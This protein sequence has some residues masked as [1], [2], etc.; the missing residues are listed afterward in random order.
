MFQPRSRTI[1]GLGL[2][3]ALAVAGPQVAGAAQKS[4]AR[5][6]NGS[7][8]T[9]SNGEAAVTGAT[10]TSI[11]TAVA[12]KYPGATVNRAST[13]TDGKSTDAYEAKVT[14]ADGTRI[15]VFLD[16]AFA[17]TGEKA[18]TG[19]GGHR[20]RHGGRGRGGNGETPLTGATLA[21]VKSAVLA[22]YPGSTVDRASTETDGKSTDAY[23]AKV[24][25]ADGTKIEV[26]LDKAF[27]VTG[28]KAQP[29]RPSKTSSTTTSTTSSN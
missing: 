28:N 26:F 8:G 7:Q 24:T 11:Q 16:S 2:V 12:A 1:A 18:D 22:A 15:E 14:K 10:L 19:R 20:G 21:S 3:A 29:A 6:A 9:P 27:T 25:K 13:E 17:V 23:E 5:A 4:S